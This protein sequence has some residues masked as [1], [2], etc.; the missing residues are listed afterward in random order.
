M[1]KTIAILLTTFLAAS[2][3]LADS[4]TAI[5]VSA[6]NK[7]KILKEMREL[8][9]S[10]QLV[11]DGVIKNDM[12]QVEK[13]ARKVGMNMT[14]GTPPEV[15]RVLPQRF[16]ALGPGVHRSFERI[17]DEADGFGDTQK[18]LTILAD[19]Q[20]SCVACHDIYRFEVKQ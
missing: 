20:S 2:P 15:A 18:I 4:R 9:R 13:A 12:E 19:T 5:E 14:G 16:R 8:L 7:T 6:Q 1:K 11:L 17:A 10:S 3:V